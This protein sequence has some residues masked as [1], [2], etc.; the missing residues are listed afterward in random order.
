VTAGRVW[1]RPARGI[2]LLLERRTALISQAVTSQV[3]LR[4][5]EAV[6]SSA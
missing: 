4:Y 6:E 3:E 2:S 5:A 1:P